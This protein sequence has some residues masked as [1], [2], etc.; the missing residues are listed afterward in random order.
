MDGT[1]NKNNLGANAMLAVS[2]AFAKAMANSK[3]I[4]IFKLFDGPYEL[5]TPFVNVINGGAHADNGLDIQEFM[6]VP[7]GFNS[8]SDKVKA[9]SEIFH[10]LKDI[11]KQAGYSTNVGDEGGFCSKFREK[12]SGI[13]NDNERNQ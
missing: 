9:A 2:L 8:F 5:P 12:C 11:I 7:H 13:G 4:P 6:I 3:N 10:N 1:E